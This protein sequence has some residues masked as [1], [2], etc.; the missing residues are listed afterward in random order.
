MRQIIC[1][2]G[3]ILYISKFYGKNIVKFPY[4]SKIYIKLYYF[5]MYRTLKIFILQSE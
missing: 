3:G 1:I 2:L 4:F 5:F